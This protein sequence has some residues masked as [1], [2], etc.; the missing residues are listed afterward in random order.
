MIVNSKFGAGEAVPLL[1]TRL[2]YPLWSL[3]RRSHPD[4]AGLAWVV[5]VLELAR[6]EP[7]GLRELRA[8]QRLLEQ[9]GILHLAGDGIVSSGGV[10]LPF[11]GRARRFPQGFAHLS[12]RT[13]APAV[14]VFAT[15]APSGRSID[16]QILP[17]LPSGQDGANLA[18]RV[19]VMLDAYAQLLGRMWRTHPSNIQPPQ[20]R[21]Y[22]ALPRLGEPPAPEP[23]RSSPA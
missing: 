6:M 10:V 18:D 9:G 4:M 8:A 3:E 19:R 12:V 1:F 2:G 11:L 17:P 13:G 7:L 21:K 15:L 16:I 23:R 20:L 22:V 5:R 14:P